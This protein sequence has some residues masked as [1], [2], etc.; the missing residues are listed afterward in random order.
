MLSKKNELEL[1]VRFD[2][3]ERIIKAIR[4]IEGRNSH[5]E[6]RYWTIPYKKETIATFIRAME[7]YR[8]YV[9][10]ELQDE[11]NLLK[12]VQKNNILN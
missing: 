7:Q 8:I 11:Y 10:E 4:E 2:Y 1:I 12:L 9:S 5:K 3:D 6:K